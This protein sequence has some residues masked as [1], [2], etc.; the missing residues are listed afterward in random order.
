MGERGVSADLKATAINLRTP[1][2]SIAGIGDKRAEVLEA[3]GIRTVEDLLHLPARAG[4]TGA[5][6]AL[7]RSILLRF[8]WQIGVRRA[9]RELSRSPWRRLL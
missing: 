9:I 1:V 4:R 6:G 2:A 3:R 5:T 7:S 8:G